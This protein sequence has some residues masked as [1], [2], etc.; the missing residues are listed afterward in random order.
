MAVVSGIVATLVG[1]GIGCMVLE[2]TLRALRVY[3][4]RD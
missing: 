1:I 3:L 4:K 2:L